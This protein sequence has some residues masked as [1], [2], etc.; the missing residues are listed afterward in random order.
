MPVPPGKP[1]FLIVTL[2]R[3]PQISPW[4]ICLQRSM[5]SPWPPTHLQPPLIQ[6]NPMANYANN[7]SPL[8]RSNS[9]EKNSPTPWLLS[10]R[11]LETF[12][13]SVKNT[14][15]NSSDHNHSMH[16]YELFQNI[17]PS[18]VTD[19]FMWMRETDRNLYKTALGSLASNRKLR[20]PFLQKKPVTEQSPG[21]TRLSSSSPV[22]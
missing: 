19:M 13:A 10:P 4:Q 22:T 21:C 7:T 2:L 18:I 3:E 8:A 5:S 6:K 15:S 11:P 16:A 20:L 14:P 17:K 1:A 9:T 12:C